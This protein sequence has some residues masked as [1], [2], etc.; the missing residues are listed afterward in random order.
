MCRWFDSAP[1][2][3]YIR[4]S[5]RKCATLFYCTV[6]AQFSLCL[7]SSATLKNQI[8]S[9]CK[10][11]KDAGAPHAN[12]PTKKAAQAPMQ[13]V[14]A[15]DGEVVLY[16]RVT[17][18]RWQARFKLNDSKWHRISTKQR[19]LEYATKAACEAYCRRRLNIDPPCR[20]KFDPGRVAAI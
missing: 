5:R 8:F 20:F 15:R 11:E 19:N 3:Q 2:H 13:L 14:Y 10:M 16:K 9:S 17:S 12:T 6:L 18:A 4:R 7:A 1:G